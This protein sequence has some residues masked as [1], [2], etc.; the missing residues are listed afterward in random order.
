MNRFS[1][2]GLVVVLV[3]LVAA[4]M[5]CDRGNSPD[6]RQRDGAAASAPESIRPVASAANPP[7]VSSAARAQAESI[8]GERCAVCHGDN[9]DGNGPGAEN[10]KPR[11]IDFHNPKWQ[12]SVSDAHSARA[13]VHGGS[14]VGLSASMAANPD[15][16]NKPE[17]VA[18]LVE[19][20]RKLGK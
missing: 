3:P 6:E 20:I 18:A 13:I 12:R 17:V 15:L 2:A 8:F 11:P 16:E 9:G 7:A 14:A 10:L 1:R 5:S 19:R 4:A